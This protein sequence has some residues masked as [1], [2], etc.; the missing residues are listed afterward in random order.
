MFQIASGLV[1][2]NNL[3][4]KTTGAS[5]QYNGATYDTSGEITTFEA[6]AI[7]TDPLFVGTGT[8]PYSLQTGSPAINAGVNVGL[9]TDILGNTVPSGEGYD[10]GAYE[11]QQ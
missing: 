8:H 9:T 4:Y 3:Y 2:T 1:H 10:I 11:R 5:L 6:S 7:T